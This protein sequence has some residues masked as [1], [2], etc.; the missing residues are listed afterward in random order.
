MSSSRLTFITESLP[1]FTVDVPAQVDLQVSGGTPPYTFDIT[2]GTLPRGLQLSQ[3]GSISGKAARQAD[4][5]ISVR[6]KDYTG[7]TLTETLAVRVN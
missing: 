6:V 2:E 3:T 7:A 1:D 5:K 4:T